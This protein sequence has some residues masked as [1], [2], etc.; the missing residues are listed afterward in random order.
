MEM[1]FIIVEEMFVNFNRQDF[2]MV[3][4]MKCKSCGM[5]MLIEEDQEEFKNLAK[6]KCEQAIRKSESGSPTRSKDLF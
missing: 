1:S 4:Y 5:K 3:N 6:M 2:V